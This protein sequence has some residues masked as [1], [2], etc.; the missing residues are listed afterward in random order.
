MASF[1]RFA[2]LA[3]LVV[4]VALAAPSDAGMLNAGIYDVN[5]GSKVMSGSAQADL[6]LIGRRAVLES[7]GY[8]EDEIQKEL[9]ILE[10]KVGAAFTTISFYLNA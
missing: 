1:S 2:A 10:Q 8:T 4:M 6:A 3:A 9:K 7:Q 5:E